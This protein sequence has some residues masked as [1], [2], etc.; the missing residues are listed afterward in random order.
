LRFNQPREFYGLQILLLDEGLRIYH[1]NLLPST[2]ED[3]FWIALLPAELLPEGLAPYKEIFS[4]VG[5]RGIGVHWREDA[6]TSEVSQYRS[7]F[8]SW[9]L[10]TTEIENGLIYEPLMLGINPDGTL[11]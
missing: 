5:G 4:R 8:E 10:E 2:P 3:A 1:V 7:V 11:N 6:S 9:N